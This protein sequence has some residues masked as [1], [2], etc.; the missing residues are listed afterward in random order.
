MTDRRR[1][2]PGTSE[3]VP[4]GSIIQ[5][6]RGTEWDTHAS[7]PEPGGPRRPS[8][9]NS[10]GLLIG[11]L[12]LLLATGIGAFALYRPT[13]PAS[14][15]SL[16]PP[17][18]IPTKAPGADA[19]VGLW[20]LVDDSALSYHLESSGNVAADLPGQRVTQKFSMR[21]DVAGDDY[22]GDLAFAGREHYAWDRYQ[23]TMYVR[24]IGKAQWVKTA[25]SDRA[26][27]QAPF[28]GLDDRHELE[29][30]STVVENG[31]T[32]YRLVSTAAYRPS[33][34]RML[35]L[36][37]FDYPFL[38]VDVHLELFVTDAGVPVRAAFSCRVAA[39][40]QYNI[41]G[42]SGT[43]KFGFTSFGQGPKLDAPPHR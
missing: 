16:P 10:I 7:D 32:L 20:A 38:A 40:A 21:L 11:G 4:A 30:D 36:S 43:S 14:T 37:W 12:V 25:T 33:V 35:A 17:K 18:P 41:P 19:L 34:A 13:S 27:R 28:L 2:E 39:D 6:F 29:Y 9:D 1:P 22:V 26:Y 15:F 42:F 3:P 23:G 5:R 8:R 31:T 24:I